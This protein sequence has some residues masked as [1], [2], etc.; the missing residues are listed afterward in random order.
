VDPLERLLAVDE[1]AR[2]VARRCR[3]LDAQDWETYAACHTPDVV[4][5]AISSESGA[6]EPT[7]GID[8]V[9]AF[10]REQL[11]GRTTVHHVHSPEIELTS[12]VA[13]TGTWAME[14]RLWWEHDGTSY[15]LH[16][17]GHYRETYAKRDGRWLVASRRL[18]RSRVD[19]GAGP[20]G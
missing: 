4:S 17:F 5:Y 7:R 18:E 1:I 9:L 6:E 14:D 16:G 20:F 11:A 13:A 3:S 19:R 2:L 12:S 8:A 10:L 15:W